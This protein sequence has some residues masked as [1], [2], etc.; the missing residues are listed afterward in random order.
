[1]LKNPC[2]PCLPAG[3]RQAG[4]VFSPLLRS[5]FLHGG[6]LLLPL[7][8]APRAKLRNLA[9]HQS[10]F[11]NRGTIILWRTTVAVKML[12]KKA[13]RIVLVSQMIAVGTM[14]LLGPIYAI[15]VEKLG[16]DI[17]AAAAAYAIYSVVYGGL[18]ILLGKVTDKVKESEYFVIAGFFVASLSYA[19]YLLAQNPLHLF[20]I[21]AVLGVAQALNTPALDALYQKHMDNRK[22]ASE[23]GKWEGIYY[24]T[25]GITA[26]VGGGIATLIGFMPLFIIM[27]AISMVTGVYLMFLPRKV[28]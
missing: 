27:A 11:Y 6:V 24:I 21:Q 20:V 3:R 23:W 4:S 25:E 22:P 12:H 17:L 13:K 1:V 9:L 7:R 18:V 28:L 14:G 5:F 15:Y 10:R 19:G 2:L 16:G 26:A 8:P